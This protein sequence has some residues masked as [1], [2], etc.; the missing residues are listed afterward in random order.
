[1][2]KMQRRACSL[3]LLDNSAQFLER[4]VDNYTHAICQS[5]LVCSNLPN[6]STTIERAL[7]ASHKR[8]SLVIIHAPGTS[9]HGKSKGTNPLFLAL[10]PSRHNPEANSSLLLRRR[11]TAV[12]ALLGHLIP[13]TGRGNLPVAAG[14][15]LSDTLVRELLP[16]DELVGE[17]LSVHGGRV[18]VDSVRDH[19]RVE[20]EKEK[21]RGKVVNYAS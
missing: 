21:R 1:M 8:I 18:C 9:F 12:A 5:S 7:P 3:P 11:R 15:L 2:W 10:L 4:Y 6:T 17:V 20:R 13:P 19:L 16:S 14:L